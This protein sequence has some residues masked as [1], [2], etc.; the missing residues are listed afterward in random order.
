M[1]PK[2]LVYNDTDKKKSIYYEEGGNNGTAEDEIKWIFT[3]RETGKC[4]RPSFIDLLDG[5]MRSYRATPALG[6]G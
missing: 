5:L 4:E 6:P 3:Q 2:D 1:E